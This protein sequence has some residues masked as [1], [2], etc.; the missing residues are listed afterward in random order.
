[1]SGDG[2]THEKENASYSSERSEV[3][4]QR[5]ARKVGYPAASR[6]RRLRNYREGF[7]N[8]LEEYHGGQETS[9]F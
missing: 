8:D 9:I 7:N 2:R 3:R 6:L 5:P 1:L 4:P